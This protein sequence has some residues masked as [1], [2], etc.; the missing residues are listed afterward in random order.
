MRSADWARV[1]S[2]WGTQPRFKFFPM[3]QALIRITNTNTRRST[4]LFFECSTGAVPRRSGLATKG[5]RGDQIQYPTSLLL[6]L[7][8]AKFVD[9]TPL[10]LPREPRRKPSV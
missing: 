10:P 8:G 1:P 2:S 4:V 7:R 9:F 6:R 5:I 3:Y